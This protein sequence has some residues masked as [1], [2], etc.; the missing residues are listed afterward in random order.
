MKLRNGW[1]HLERLAGG[2]NARS[3]VPVLGSG[4][5]TQAVMSA[6]LT[7]KPGDSFPAP[8]DWLALLRGVAKEFDCA[9][10]ISHIEVD[11]PGQT[12]LLWDAMAV[13]L[14]AR[15]SGLQQ[16]HAWESKMRRSV[17]RR[18]RDDVLTSELAEPF[19]ESFLRLG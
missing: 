8:V 7:M 11:V 9:R 13:E 4:F 10:A 16:A 19:V 12:T 3:L 2:P 17:A 15:S 14:T 5:V 1:R 18:L 6:R